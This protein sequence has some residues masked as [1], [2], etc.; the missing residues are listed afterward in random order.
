[1]Q[2]KASKNATTLWKIRLLMLGIIPAFFAALLF[3]FG[4][5][6]FCFATLIW[7]TIFLILAFIYY[8]LWYKQFSCSITNE[9]AVVNS[10]LFFRTCRSIGIDKVQ[11]AV[12]MQTPLQRLLN[13][14]TVVIFAAGGAI[15]LPNLDKADGET[16]RRNVMV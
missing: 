12:L 10:G 9:N 6:L 16:I 15:M 8:P 11:Y 13:L 1:M 7:I 4:S 14:V 5:R 2:Y 3:N